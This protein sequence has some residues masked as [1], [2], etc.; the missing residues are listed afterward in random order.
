M[1]ELKKFIKVDPKKLSKERAERVE[2]L[3]SRCVDQERAKLE[4]AIFE[5]ENTVDN[6]SD[7]TSL[8]NFTKDSATNWVRKRNNALNDLKEAKAEL[9][10]FNANFPV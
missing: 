3:L 10:L 6:V 2:K 9:E 4:D 8:E 5:C 7:I 1:S